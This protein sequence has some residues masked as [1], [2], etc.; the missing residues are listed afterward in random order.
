MLLTEMDFNVKNPIKRTRQGHQKYIH[1]YKKDLLLVNQK[2]GTILELHFGIYKYGLL[3]RQEEKILFSKLS[4]VEI[5]GG[6]LLTMNKDYTFLYLLYHGVHH[7]FFRLFRL[8]DIGEAL[9]RWEIN[10]PYVYR[11]AKELGIERIVC[12]GL[13]LVNEYFKVEIPY[14]YHDLIRSNRSLL[15]KM[16]VLCVK[17]IEGPESEG[18]IMKFRRYRINLLLKPGLRY[19]WAVIS[20]IFHRWYIRKFLLRG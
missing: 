10:H 12:L 2:N 16:K 3:S 9:I 15:R 20:S 5:G 18:I 7:L 4:E 8:K 17:R 1:K 19:K 6:I 14:I 13:I 11:L